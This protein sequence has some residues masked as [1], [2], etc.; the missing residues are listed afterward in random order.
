MSI[1]ILTGPPASG[2]T[3]VAP[4]IACQRTR[5]AIIDVDQV[6]WM[7]AHPHAAP[8]EGEEGKRQCRLGVENA[9]LLAQSFAEDGCDVLILDFLWDYTAPI[10]RQRLAA[11]QP[12]IILLM[13]SL[14]ETQRRN[15]ARGWL[16]AHEVEM[17]YA[18]LQSIT[19][20]DIR[21]DNTNLPVEALA[22]KILT[23]MES[24]KS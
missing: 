17:L 11:Y 15:R 10:Y 1:V 3:S 9:C 22:A 12:E 13:P 5:C 21:I 14:E 16:P 6:R 18:N 20:Y 8:W 4:L 24:P 23:H 7:L 2:K 19:D